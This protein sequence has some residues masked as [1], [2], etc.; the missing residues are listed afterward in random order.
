[1]SK[2]KN[3]K[4]EKQNLYDPTYAPAQIIKV[5]CKKC[6]HVDK[7]YKWEARW[8]FGILYLFTILNLIGLII[9]FVGTEPYICPK[10]G[11]RNQL[12]KILNNNKRVPQKCLST[13]AFIGISIPFLVITVLVFILIM[14]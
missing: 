4:K 7:P 6:G 3:L 11:E 2:E 8:T 12:V 10:C 9:Y 5:E 14:L 13:K 1:M